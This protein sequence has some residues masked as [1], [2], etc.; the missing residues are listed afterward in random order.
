MISALINQSEG[1]APDFWKAKTC[2][3]IL[4][5]LFK[6]ILRIIKKIRAISSPADIGLFKVNSTNIRKTCVICSK[7][8]IKS[9]FIVNFE[10]ISHL[11]L[12]LILLTLNRSMLLGITRRWLDLKQTMCLL[13]CLFYLL[14]HDRGLRCLFY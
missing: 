2:C 7:L 9:V 13:C 5:D 4:K 6:K 8:T 3:T 14:Y 10:D 1:L 11:F 12:V